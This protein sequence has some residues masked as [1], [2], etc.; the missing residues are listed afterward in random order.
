LPKIRRN[1]KRDQKHLRSLQTAGWRVL[2]IWECEIS[3]VRKLKQLR[4]KILRQ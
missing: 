4:R 3:N 2:A 1:K